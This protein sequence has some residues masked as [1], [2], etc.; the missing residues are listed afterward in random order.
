MAGGKIVDIAC[1]VAPPISAAGAQNAAATADYYG[2][3]RIAT[4]A[5]S[6]RF[7]IPMKWVG[8]WWSITAIGLDIQLLFGGSSAEVAL[9]E[10]STVS[11]ENITLVATTGITIAAG[12]TKQIY[13][14]KSSSITDFAFISSG[15]SGYVEI[16]PSSNPDAANIK[17]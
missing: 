14:P 6:Q 2:V 17:G 10:P 3:F 7:N 15:T 8:R 1:D 5:S 16:Y 13:V 11:S 12:E 9:D 4:S